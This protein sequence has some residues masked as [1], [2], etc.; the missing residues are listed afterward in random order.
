[1]TK[2]I[3]YLPLL[4]GFTLSWTNFALSA[5]DKTTLWQPLLNI[6]MSMI[7]ILFQF[8]PY[9][10]VLFAIW[11]LISTLSSLIWQFAWGM[12]KQEIPPWFE[13]E[14]STYNNAFGNWFAMRSFRKQHGYRYTPE[15]IARFNR[16]SMEFYATKRQKKW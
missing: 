11:W 13:N 6:G 9:L 12:K 3:K 5:T 10:L 16:Q 15:Q 14:S 2:L 1:M 8:W 7:T 4:I